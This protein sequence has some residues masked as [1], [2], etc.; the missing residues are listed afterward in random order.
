MFRILLKTAWRNLWKTKFY[1]GIS[2]LG[3][4]LGLT[5]AIFIA[6]WIDSELSFNQVSDNSKN[7]YRVSSIIGDGDSKQ[8]WGG[9]VG[10]VAYFAKKE[11][12][13]VK[14]AAR[15][16]DNYSYRIYS[17]EDK[18]LEAGSSAG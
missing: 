14:I 3:L 17:T 4:S 15:V 12:P 13:E 8:T 6:V 7:I 16:R 10:P 9:S 5:A 1:N 18:D 2:L 11:V